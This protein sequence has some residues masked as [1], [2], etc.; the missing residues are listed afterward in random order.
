MN[1][2]ESFETGAFNELI[3]CLFQDVREVFNLNPY[4][5]ANSDGEQFSQDAAQVKN[6]YL[7]D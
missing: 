5:V 4:F 1:K 7:E 6:W 3:N 2:F